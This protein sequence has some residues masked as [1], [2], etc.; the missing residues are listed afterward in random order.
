MLAPCHPGDTLLFCVDR[1]TFVLQSTLLCPL[2]LTIKRA[3]TEN[4]LSRRS[5]RLNCS[6]CDNTSGVQYVAGNG[7]GFRYFECLSFSASLMEEPQLFAFESFVHHLDLALAHTTCVH[8]AVSLIAQPQSRRNRP[9]RGGMGACSATFKVTQSTHSWLAF[10]CFAWCCARWRPRRLL[11]PT[12]LEKRSKEK[13]LKKAT[14]TSLPIRVE[15]ALRNRAPGQQELKE[16][17]RKTLNK[18]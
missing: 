11:M 6:S 12:V 9:V 7:L 13:G 10:Y 5:Q 2:R 17:G 16:G 15:M 18:R 8:E 4:S 14:E 1:H 3:K